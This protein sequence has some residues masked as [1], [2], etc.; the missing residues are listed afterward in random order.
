MRT[1][2]IVGS[3][4]KTRDYAPFGNPNKD[5]WV[6]NEVLGLGKVPRADAVYQMHAEPIWKNPTNRNDPNHYQWLQKTNVPVYMLD[7]YAEVPAS[8]KYPLKNLCYSLLNLFRRSDGQQIRYFTSSVAYAIAQAIYK[9]YQRIELYGVEMETNT[10]Y[11]YQRDG[12]YF[13]IGVAIGRGIEVVLHEESGLFRSPLYGYEG[14]IELKTADFETRLAELRPLV[15][16]NETRLKQANEAQATAL[17]KAMT[18]TNEEKPV[19]LKE[20]FAAI[21]LQA[22]AVMD[23]GMLDGAIQ[24]NERYLSKAAAMDSAA[25]A[26][27]FSRQEFEQTAGKTQETQAQYE[28]LMHNTGGQATTLWKQLEASAGQPDEARDSIAEQYMAAHE[29]YLKAGYEYGRMTGVIQENMQYLNKVDELIRM[30][31]GAKSE[32]AITRAREVVNA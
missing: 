28:A 26:I 9:G 5:I 1:V 22:S 32:E 20:F 27:L 15:E 24:E 29:A 2:A 17:E 4:P 14:D 10:E 18:A 13:W 12:V 7:R 21:K 3:H 19:I 23:W 31:G 11:T 16:K 6:F 25:G 8:V 30:A